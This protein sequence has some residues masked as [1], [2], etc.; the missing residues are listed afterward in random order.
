MNIIFTVL[1]R[2]PIEIRESARTLDRAKSAPCRIGFDAIYALKE[3]NM[4]GSFARWSHNVLLT[5][6]GLLTIAYLVTAK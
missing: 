5:A 2:W 6:S 1:R 4:L 3:T